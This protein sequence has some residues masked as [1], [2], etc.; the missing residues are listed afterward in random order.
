MIAAPTGGFASDDIGSEFDA[1]AKYIYRKSFV[2]K[3]G[4]GHFFPG[5]L[6]TS[7]KHGA[8]LTYAY[9]I[10]LPLQDRKRY[11]A[12][13]GGTDTMQALHSQIE[14]Q[15]D[16][17]LRGWERKREELQDAVS[18]CLPSLHRRAYHYLGNSHDAEDAVQ[19]AL[20]SAYR[21]LDQFKGDAKMT[22]WLTSIVTNSAL[23]QIRRRPRHPHSSID[24]PSAD[25]QNSCVADRLVDVRP[26]PEDECAMSELRGHLRQVLGE[27]SPSF[28]KAIQLCDLEGLTTSEA[29]HLLGV[30]ESTLK[31]RVSRARSQLKRHAKHGLKRTTRSLKMPKFGV[32]QPA[33]N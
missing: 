17:A 27:L 8:P 18:R 14:D 9:G 12:A 28:Q 24:E 7:E 33:T 2:T 21:H 16:L 20:L 29:A 3:I 15:P 6:M 30:R 23:T 11:R 1:P 5:E 13:L 25:G 10:Y 32:Y 31:S 26:S 19:D 22:T 4:V